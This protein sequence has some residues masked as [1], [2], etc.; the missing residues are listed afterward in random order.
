MIFLE[1]RWHSSNKIFPFYLAFHSLCREI[2]FRKS[3]VLTERRRKSSPPGHGS[4]LC[5]VILPH[6]MWILSFLHFCFNWW[7]YCYSWLG[8][9]ECSKFTLTWTVPFW[10]FKSYFSLLLSSLISLTQLS[11]CGFRARVENRAGK[12]VLQTFPSQ[13]WHPIANTLL[14][15]CCLLV[16]F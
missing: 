4:L 14:S 11:F 2:A 1:S 7:I 15:A 9:D 16:R 12:S 13:K 8:Y 3:I 5:G 6:V 10:V